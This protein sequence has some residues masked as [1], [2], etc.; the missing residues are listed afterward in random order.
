MLG[1]CLQDRYIN[2][3]LLRLFLGH[4]NTVGTLFLPQTAHTG[5]LTIS[6]YLSAF[7]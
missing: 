5:S 2:R 7:V 1:S 3:S 6:W 4:L